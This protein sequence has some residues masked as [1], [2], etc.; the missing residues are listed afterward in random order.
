MEGIVLD[1]LDAEN[2]MGAMWPVHFG[3]IGWTVKD[4]YS[5][6]VPE[7]N[8]DFLSFDLQTC[9]NQIDE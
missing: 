5:V 7:A 6:N 9:H 8:A 3:V 4:D 2:V 1:T